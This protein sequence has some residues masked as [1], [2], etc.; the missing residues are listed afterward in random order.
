MKDQKKHEHRHVSSTNFNL[1]S[2]RSHTIFTLTIESSPC[3]DNCEGGA[4]LI[5]LAGSESSEAETTDVRRKEGSY[6]NKRNSIRILEERLE[7]TNAL[8]KQMWAEVQLDKRLHFDKDITVGLICS[9]LLNLAEYNVHMAKLLDEGR[10]KAATEFA[11]SLIQTLL[12]NDSKVISTLHNFVDALAKLE[13]RLGSPESL[14]QLVEV[15]RNPAPNPATLFAVFLLFYLPIKAFLE[16][17]IPDSP[18]MVVELIMQ[19][20]KLASLKEL[21]LNAKWIL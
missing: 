19:K 4:N 12:I 21:S 3:G 11:I 14:Q 5:D 7:A 10:N 9:E 6:I 13:A 16:H 18:E 8:N 20:V 17:G 15:A 1:L 2:S